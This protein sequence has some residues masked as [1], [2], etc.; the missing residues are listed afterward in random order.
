MD[1]KQ[2]QG[3]NALNLLVDEVPHYTRNTVFLEVAPL[4][5]GSQAC[6]L[7]LELNL[8]PS[9][10]SSLSTMALGTSHPP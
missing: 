1:T 6:G 4:A 10:V 5:H 7:G 2:D 3:T 9:C 8:W